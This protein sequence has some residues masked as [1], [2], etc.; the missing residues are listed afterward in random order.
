MRSRAGTGASPPRCSRAGAE[1]TRR[2]LGFGGCLLG[3]AVCFFVS[4]LTLPMLALRPAKF[5]L[6]FRCAA[7]SGLSSP[8]L[9]TPPQPREPAR[10][11]R[12]RRTLRPRVRSSPCARF[13]VLI[14]PLNHA[15]HLISKERLPFSLAYLS[16]LGLTLYFS[17]GVRPF[18]PSCVLAQH[19]LTHAHPCHPQ[20][21]SYIGSLICA[22]V[23]VRARCRRWGSRD[24]DGAAGRRAR[25]LRPRLLPRRRP[26]AALRRAD[27]PARRG[28]PP[29]AIATPT[30]LPRPRP[31]SRTYSL[32]GHRKHS[33]IY[34]PAADT[35]YHNLYIAPLYYY[36][37][38]KAAFSRLARSTY[39]YTVR[40]VIQQHRPYR[41]SP[42]RPSSGS[43]KPAV[44]LSLRAMT[45]IYRSYCAHPSARVSFP[46]TQNP[47]ISL[48]AHQ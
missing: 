17:L 26:D 11:V 47:A 15:K 21:H 36:Y 20:A 7:H 37:Y 30:S 23:Q 22:I 27:G 24:A 41:A 43:C 44:S 39:S 14:G 48:P 4:F 34:P 12:V 6:S 46:C 40:L 28:Q 35:P 32:T 10:H 2:L 45:S 31:R 38:S 42:S 29:P 16:S 19:A 9:L 25:V 18:P 1:R 33:A 3:A 5:A 13:S 8:R